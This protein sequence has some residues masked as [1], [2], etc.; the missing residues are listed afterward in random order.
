MKG[1]NAQPDLT[2]FIDTNI[3]LYSFIESQDIEKTKIARA[4]IKDCE[5]VISTQ[6]INE[7]FVNLIKI[8]RPSTGKDVQNSNFV[9]NFLII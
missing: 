2:Y 3:W 9:S 5:I 4:V 8:E 7:I 1:F 6:I